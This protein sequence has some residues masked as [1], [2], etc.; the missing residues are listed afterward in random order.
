MK[1][2]TVLGA[3]PQFIKSAP[4][5]QAFMKSGSINE[6]IIHTGQHYDVNMSD[7]FFEELGI[8]APKY[9]LGISGLSHG[10]M[11]GRML[12]ELEEVFIHEKPDWVL[13]FGDTNSTLAGALAASKL[14]LRVAHVEAGLR[15]FNPQMPEEIN[16]ILTD[17]CSNIL[18]TPTPTATENLRQ[19]GIGGPRV[20]EVGDVMYDAA[21]LFNQAA[22]RNSIA[23]K[24]NLEKH[25]FVLATIHRQENTDDVNRLRVILNGLGKV[26]ETIPVAFPMHPRTRYRIKEMGLT[27]NEAIHV[28]DP[29]GFLD[30]LSLEKQA[31]VIATDSGGLQKEAYFQRVPCVTLRDETE[32]VE[33]VHSGWNR[34]CPPISEDIIARTILSAIGN[35]GREVSL[36]GNGTASSLITNELILRA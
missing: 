35:S 6:V 22:E 4:V 27:V 12:E 26:A 5:S 1:V 15:S 25:R 7:I 21:I 17:H 29:L 11:T 14:H 13:V 31:A 8:P 2:C 36:Y 24:M 3:R 19:E 32:W 18:F 33:L 9:H 30:L 10:A 20:A 28:I 16:R 34:L 23:E